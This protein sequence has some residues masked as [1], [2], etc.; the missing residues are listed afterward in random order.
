ML[1]GIVLIDKPSN[2]TSGEVVRRVKEI[3][4]IKKAGHSGTLDPKATGVLLV[5]INEA[6]K[7]MPFFM[8]LDKEY[9][10]RMLL[11]GDVGKDVILAC[12]DK[13]IGD[14]KQLPPKKSAVKRVERTRKVYSFDVRSVEGREVVFKIK[15]EA[16]T[17]IRKIV[18][19]FGQSI[20]CGA[21]LTELR[22]IKVGN[23][24]ESE[25][26]QVEDLKKSHVIKLEEAL[27]RVKIKKVYVKSTAIKKIR[28]GI[29]IVGNDIENY[30]RNIKNE[31]LV[32]VYTKDKIVAIG[33][34]K[35]NFD[36]FNDK[37]ILVRIKRVFKTDD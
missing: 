6:T 30:N 1:N 3:L 27:E 8:D 37:K 16:G 36:N 33:I 20:G 26:V 14:V 5:A 21:H 10:G 35:Q 12:I 23:F 31:D 32:G 18:H 28:N 24:S 19:D 7:A 34:A 11:H 25:C 17:Y 15:C 22:R 9:V 13:F 29:P 2:L 4:S